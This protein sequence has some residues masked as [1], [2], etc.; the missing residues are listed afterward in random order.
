MPAIEFEDGAVQIDATII[1]EGLGIEPALVQ[2]RMREGRITIRHERGTDEDAGR[3]R[4]TFFSAAD[5]CL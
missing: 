4:L 5:V 2:A 1:A 3:Q